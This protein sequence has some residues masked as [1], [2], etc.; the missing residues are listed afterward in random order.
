MRRRTFLSAAVA[1]PWVTRWAWADDLPEDVRITRIVAFEIS[2]RRS[3]LAG[4]NAR[5][6]VHGETATDRLE[7]RE[8]L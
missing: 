6:D 7:H 1:M 8:L 4:K 5:L 2:S 3:K